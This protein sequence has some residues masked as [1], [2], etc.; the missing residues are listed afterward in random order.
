[1]YCLKIETLTGKQL[2]VNSL[3]LF[4]TLKKA[5][6]SATL[7]SKMIPKVLVTLCLLMHGLRSLLAMRLNLDRTFIKVLLTRKYCCKYKVSTV[8]SPTCCVKYNAY[9]ACKGLKSV[10]NT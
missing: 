1:K 3:E 5:K 9:T 2:L 8:F 6:T 10:I 7:S 4:K